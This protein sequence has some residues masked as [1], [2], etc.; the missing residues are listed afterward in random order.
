MESLEDMKKRLASM[1][2]RKNAS[3]QESDIDYARELSEA[4]DI[5]KKEI[6]ELEEQINSLP[7]ISETPLTESNT[8]ITPNADVAKTEL[9][10]IRRILES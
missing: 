4:I 6:S 9:E 2:K 5:I 7:D 3:E 10:K 8:K 1:Q